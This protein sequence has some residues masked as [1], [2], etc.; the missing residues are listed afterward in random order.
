MLIFYDVISFDADDFC[1]HCSP[2]YLYLSRRYFHHHAEL[3]TLL[4]ACFNVFGIKYDRSLLKCNACNLVLHIDYTCAL[5]THTF[6]TWKSQDANPSNGV[7][8]FDDRINV[9]Y[10]KKNVRVF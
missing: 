10:E 8:F 1:F 7:R 9:L 3:A 4:S 5:I 6:S 2:I